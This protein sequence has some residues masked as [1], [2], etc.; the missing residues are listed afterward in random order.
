MR[1]ILLSLSFFFAARLAAQVAPLPVICGNEL[2]DHIIAERYPALK[3]GFDQTFEEARAR[4]RDTD[5]ISDRSQLT[6]KIVAHVVWKN[7]EEN[8]P[9]S[10]ILNQ[11][12]IL[13]QDFNRLNPDTGNLRP[14]FLPAAGNPNIKFE[15]DTIRRVQTTQ[16]FSINLTSGDLLANLKSSAQGGSDAWD[17]ERYLNLWICRI[18]PTTVFGIPL[19]QILGFAFPPNNLPNWPADSGAPNPNQDGV[20]VDFR[21]VGSNNPNPISNPG[22][23]GAFLIRGRTPVH[24]IGHY[25]GLRHIWGDGGLLGL[26]NDC[27]QSDGIDDTPFA[28]AQSNFDCDKTR[29]SCVKVEP[30]YGMDVPDMVENYM[31]YSQED[32][33][34]LLTKGQAALMRAVLDG[35][36]KKL[37]ETSHTHHPSVPAAPAPSLWPNPAGDGF[38]VEFALPEPAPYSLRLIAADGRTHI[39]HSEQSGANAGQHRMRFDASHLPTGW[40][41]VQLSSPQAVHTRSLLI[42]H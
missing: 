17:T 27:N 6:I 22:G 11:I 1:F 8:L 16:N 26:P 35:P 25:L 41:A 33:M 29:N 13:N 5:L 7:P 31:D 2:F 19:G 39:L 32:C 4:A 12:A 42:K 14:V 38:W 23:G 18:Q 10:V 28:N 21:T 30:F 36:R 40:Y 15:L 9:D 24:E 3:R 37:V 20:V 34:N